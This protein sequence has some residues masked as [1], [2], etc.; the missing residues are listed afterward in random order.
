MTGVQTCAL[1]ISAFA[2]FEA[3]L[4]EAA[5]FAFAAEELAHLLGT[6]FRKRIA[7]LATSMWGADPWS[8]G[9]YSHALPGHAGDR[10]RLAAP[11]EQRLFF[12]GEACSAHAYS[13]AH[14]AWQTGVAAAEAALAALGLDPGPA[15][16][17]DEA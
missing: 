13:T 3:R 11:V 2:A 6:S 9:A 7:P 4:A 14:G 16:G 12:A 1:P 8:R 17:D 10:A 15:P 5:F